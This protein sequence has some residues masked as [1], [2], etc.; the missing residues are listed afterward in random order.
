MD[1]SRLCVVEWLAFGVAD[2][3]RICCMDLEKSSGASLV[4]FPSIPSTQLG[5]MSAGRPNDMV[6]TF[7]G[8]LEG[9][10]RLYIGRRIPWLSLYATQNASPCAIQSRHSPEG[11]SAAAWAS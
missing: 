4:L 11:W 1:Q 6:G 3:W 5:R 10:N 8:F 7:L 9:Q 2:C